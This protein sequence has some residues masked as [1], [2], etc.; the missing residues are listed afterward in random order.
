M[1]TMSYWTNP[2]AN[3]IPSIRLIFWTE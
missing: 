1:Q 2:R 3:P